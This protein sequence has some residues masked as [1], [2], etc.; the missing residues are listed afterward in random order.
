MQQSAGPGVIA[1]GEEQRAELVRATKI[2]ELD[3]WKK[4]D[5]REPRRASHVSKQKVETRRVITWKTADGRKC[6]QARL[7][8]KGDQDPDLREGSADTSGCASL[9]SSH[10]QVISLR[11]IKKWE[12]R[13]LDIKNAFAQADGFA[14]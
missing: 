11:A 5:V 13:S 14:L 7:V 10:L 12:L 3:S 9:R 6:V 8:A 2:Q 1:G 4:F